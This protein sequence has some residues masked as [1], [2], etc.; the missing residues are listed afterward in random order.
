MRR[1]WIWGLI[2]LTVACAMTAGDAMAQRTRQRGGEGD[3]EGGTKDRPR[4]ERPDRERPGGQRPD[5]DPAEIAK[6]CVERATTMAEHCAKRNTEAAQRCVAEIEELLAAGQA[7]EAEQV[8]A[9]CARRIKMGSDRCVRRISMGCR[10]CVRVLTQLEADS[11]LIDRVK[12]A[13]GAAA[14]SVEQSCDEALLT[15]RGAFR[16]G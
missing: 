7:E 5:V 13:C 4:V 3:C 11:A 10:R 1:N 2:V 15:I 16:A 8:A 14:K 6:K 9:N 12:N